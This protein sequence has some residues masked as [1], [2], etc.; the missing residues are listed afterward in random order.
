MYVRCI[1]GGGGSRL[2]RRNVRFG[3][4][5][6]ILHSREG[7]TEKSTAAVVGRTRAFGRVTKPR[8]TRERINYRRFYNKIYACG[9]IYIYAPLAEMTSDQT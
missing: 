2:R 8:D 7:A 6:Y 1:R 3:A 4:R 5:A 9:Y